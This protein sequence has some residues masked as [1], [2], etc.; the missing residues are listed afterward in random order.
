MNVNPVIP[1][2][3]QALSYGFC[4]LY[5]ALLVTALVLVAR[6]SRLSAVTK[7]LFALMIIAVPVLG[8]VVAIIVTTSKRWARTVPRS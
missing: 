8:A 3:S 7:L 2:E 1:W 5:L 6:N 4:A